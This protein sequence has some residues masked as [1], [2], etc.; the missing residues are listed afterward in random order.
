MKTKVKSTS[1]SEVH[2]KHLWAKLNIPT[3]Q[4]IT[5]SVMNIFILDFKYT[6]LRAP[7]D[8]LL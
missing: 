3:I 2:E 8:F 6:A 5:D 1:Q 7:E 4:D